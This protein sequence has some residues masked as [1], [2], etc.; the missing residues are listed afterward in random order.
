[1]YKQEVNYSAVRKKATELQ[2][3]ITNRSLTLNQKIKLQHQ[4]MINLA[5]LI[6]MLGLKASNRRVIIGT[7]RRYLNKLENDRRMNM[8]QRLLRPPTT[9]PFRTVISTAPA[10]TASPRRTKTATR[11]A[12]P[13]RTKTATRSA[14]PRRAK[15]A[16]RSAEKKKKPTTVISRLKNMFSRKRK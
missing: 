13:R 8:A 6:E 9:N 7:A 5:D 15:T 10:A 11:S 2:K 14:S 1:M 4:R 12:S 16:T 3:P